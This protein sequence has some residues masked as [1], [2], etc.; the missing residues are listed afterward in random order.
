ME[1]LDQEKSAWAWAEAMSSR[2]LSNPKH[3]FDCFLEV[4]GPQGEVGSSYYTI[5]RYT[6]SFLEKYFAERR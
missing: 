5:Y 4:V 1:D 3:V 6:H 2:I